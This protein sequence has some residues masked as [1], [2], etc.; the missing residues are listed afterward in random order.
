MKGRGVGMK[1]HGKVLI[2]LLGAIILLLCIQFPANKVLPNWKAMPQ[3]L[4]GQTIVL[5]PGHGGPDG[6]AKGSNNTDEKDITLKVAKL[7]KD[8]LQEAGAVVYLTREEDKDLADE[9]TKG[10]SR[11][12]SEDIRKRME[13]IHEQEANFFITIHLNAIPDTQWSGAQTFYYPSFPENKH[14]ATMIQSEIITNLENTNRTPLEIENIYLLKHTEVPGA[15]VELGFLSNEKERA[16]LESSEY[17]DQ[18]AA[19]VYKGV[20][21]YMVEEM[22]EE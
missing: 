6:G 5:D 12:K 13:F 9:E 10:F 17:Q 4:A 15:L 18:L 21:R 16:L 2:W 22:E 19:S 3:P 8:Y 11:R 1:K 20:I 14:L 7:T